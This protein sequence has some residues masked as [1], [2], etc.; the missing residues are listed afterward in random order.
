[1]DQNMKWLESCVFIDETGFNIHIRRNFD[2]SK[3]SQPAKAKVSLN[4]GIS[5]SILGAICEREKESVIKDLKNVGTLSEHFLEFIE[6]VMNTLDDHDMKGKAN[7]GRH[8]VMNNASI[9]K[10]VDTKGAIE[11][12]WYKVVHHPPYSPFLNQIE[13]FWPKVK[14]DV[15]SSTNPQ[16]GTQ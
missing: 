12:C 13:L 14:V 4:R 6:G 15:K 2:R 3:R 1:K 16:F 8:I 5:I 7:Y 10:T 11:N 9:N